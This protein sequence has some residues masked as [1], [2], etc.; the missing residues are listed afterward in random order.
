MEPP[1]YDQESNLLESFDIADNIM[2]LNSNDLNLDFEDGLDHWRFNSRKARVS[3]PN[4]SIQ[5]NIDENQFSSGE[6]S[7]KLELINEKF[8][9]SRY[10]S[11]RSGDSLHTL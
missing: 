6:R 2:D 5:M 7:L 11:L 10:F 4:H 3:D 1:D 9:A 8:T